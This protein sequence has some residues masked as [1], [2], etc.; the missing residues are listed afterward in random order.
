ME[1]RRSAQRRRI[2]KAGSIEFGGGAFDCTVR[3]LSDTGAALQVITPLFIPDRFLLVVRADHWKRACH[4]VWRK[5]KRLG[6]A[7]E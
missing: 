7:F 5:Q 1:A 3:N 4:V 6:V 2:L